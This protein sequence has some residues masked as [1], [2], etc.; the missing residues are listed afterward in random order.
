MKLFKDRSYSE[1][2]VKYQALLT[3]NSALNAERKKLEQLTELIKPEVE[4]AKE[5][6]MIEFTVDVTD[7]KTMEYDYLGIIMGKLE[8]PYIY[9]KYFKVKDR[10]YLTCA[11]EKFKA[12]KRLSHLENWML[13]FS[14]LIALTISP[15]VHWIIVWLFR[16][17]YDTSIPYP[18][19]DWNAT[20]TGEQ[21][22]TYI[23]THGFVPAFTF[24]VSVIIGMLS[25]LIFTRYSK[26]SPYNKD[27]IYWSNVKKN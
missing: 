11:K 3:D 19:T 17:Y 9:C 25:V 18:F 7:V 20:V 8:S 2:L 1:L 13:L 26:F 10:L 22:G 21:I 12:Y 4:K 5:L 15:L 24:L 14:A 27:L 6:D 23:S 16:G